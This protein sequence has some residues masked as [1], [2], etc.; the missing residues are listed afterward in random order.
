MAVISQSARAAQMVAQLRL[1]NPSF[2]AEVGTPER[3][4]LD[5]AAQAL[6]ESQIDLVGLENALNI[7]T[8]FGANLDNFVALFGF[9][10]TKATTAVG[11]VVFSRLTPSTVDIVIPSGT[12]IQSTVSAT[13][14]GFPIEFSTT[15]PVTL[16]A[17]DLKTTPTP[18]AAVFPGKLGDVPAE[19]LN[20]LVG[21]IPFG[22]TEVTN[23]TAT[24]GGADQEDDNSL[25]VR[26]KNTVFRNLAGTEDQFLALSI[27]TAFSTKAN[28]VGPISRYKEYIQLP[29]VNDQEAYAYGGG[30]E[31]LPGTARTFVFLGS[32]SAKILTI[33]ST[34][35]M[36]NGEAVVIYS[37]IS[38]D[39]DGDVDQVEKLFEGTIKE[40]QSSTTLELSGT[41]TQ[42]VKNGVVMIGS[43]RTT[44]ATEWT[45]TLSTIPYAKNIWTSTPIFVTNGQAGI[46]NYFFREGTDFTF[47]SPGKLQGDTLRAFIDG[48]GL[49]PEA[50]SQPNVTFTNVYVGGKEAVQAVTPEQ[51]VLLEYYYTSSSSRNDLSHNVT[52]C[53]DVFV[54][55]QNEQPTTTIF[56]IPQALSGSIF[57]TNP[58]SPYYV[59]NYRRVGEPTKRPLLGNFLTPLMSVPTVSLPEQVQ[60]SYEGELNNF[61]LG[62]HYWL[63]KDV[64]ENGGT[65]R[66]RDGIEWSVELQGDTTNLGP[67][68]APLSSPPKVGDP[69]LADPPEYKGIAFII[70][71]AGTPVEVSEYTYDKNIPDLQAALE[72]SRQIT[73]DVLSHSVR[74]RYFKLD[75]TVIYDPS[76]IPST[77]NTQINEVLSSYLKSQYFGAAI[78][79]S[80][81]LQQIHSVQG[82][83]NVRWTS[84]VPKAAGSIR[85][86]ETDINGLPLLGASITRVRSGNASIQEVQR[87]FVT[88]KPYRG[89][90]FV[91]FKV[92]SEIK[93]ATL[94]EIENKT[95]TEI[96]TEL[97]TA[98][99]KALTVVED[100][101]PTVGVTDHIR[102]FTITYTA[103]STQE[104][105][106]VTTDYMEGD[107]VFPEDFFLRDNELPALPIG[108]QTTKTRAL[109]ADSVPGLII[110]PR[111]QGTWLRAN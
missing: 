11:A 71:P 44:H 93:T 2:S 60:V 88:G 106:V 107:Y 48:T 99:G 49:S 67:V 13:T 18:V 70:L 16:K 108:M 91:E 97:A 35:G 31:T 102:S 63:V 22:I 75:I 92:G 8:K 39:A 40:I 111:A 78:N 84:D 23:P 38:F 85:V 4:I 74:T 21:E 12:R 72:G 86:Y 25:K 77:V 104:L 66:A 58:N 65:I 33:P 61:Y 14:D 42:P 94:T 109:P 9:A 105:P 17:E 7:D 10:R 64:S 100:V 82:V 32:T 1:L 52:N 87:L 89:N 41:P 98:S 54:D 62:T 51:I 81:L 6:S 56:A 76:V 95:A 47:N 37:G 73:T 83:N 69:A 15:S 50:K 19:T 68:P 80:D 79:L 59:E 55:G 3:F 43:T 28:V 96:K 29:A 46:A 27:S 103:K 90:V 36:A 26:F 101:Q 20:I 53:V 34:Q 5:T 45:S 110:R 24:S 57:V 30:T